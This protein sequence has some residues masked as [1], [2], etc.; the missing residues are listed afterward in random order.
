MDIPNLDLREFRE[1]SGSRRQDLKFGVS[2]DP[3]NQMEPNDVVDVCPLHHDPVLSAFRV[4]CPGFESR[5]L[6]RN[7]SLRGGTDRPVSLP[8]KGD[9][10]CR[11]YCRWTKTD[12]PGAYPD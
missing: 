12:R 7:R 11:R 5:D 4:G 2:Y 1:K 9:S 3:E 6:D 10:S 8:F